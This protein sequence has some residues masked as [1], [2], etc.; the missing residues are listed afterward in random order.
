MKRDIQA[1]KQNGFFR[2][3]LLLLLVMLPLCPFAQQQEIKYSLHNGSMQISL[4]KKAD[5][6]ALNEFIKQYD[7]GDLA[8]KRLISQ[9]FTDS[10]ISLGWKMEVN[11]NEVIVISKPLFSAD[12]IN[13]PAAR[14]KLTGTVNASGERVPGALNNQPLGYNVFRKNPFIVNDRVV[15]FLLRNNKNAKRV[16]LAGDFTDW[17]TGALPMTRT[18]SAWLLP[19]KM[20]PGKYLYKFIADGNWITDPDNKLVENDGEGNTNSVYFFTNTTFKLDGFINA[21]KVVVSGSFNH[22]NENK[23]RMNKTN[24]GWEL[25][26]F[27]DTGTYTYRFIVDGR[28]MTDPAN[29]NRYPNEFNEFNSVLQVGNPVLFTLNSHQTAQQVFLAGSFNDWREFELKLTRTDS[30]WQIPYV[31]GAGNYEYK[32]YVDGQWVDAAGKKIKASTPGSILVAGTNHVFRLKGYAGAK[33]IFLAGDFNGW[34]PN[35][36]A[37]K[38]E[39]DEWVLPI[40]LSPGKHLYKFVV[41]GSWIKDPG[42]NLWEK[43]EFDGENSIIWMK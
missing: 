16:L 13:D 36:F 25:P 29:T 7:L 37:M 43:N 42:N 12:N 4:G 8:L 3:I 39:G 15:S 19:V 35:A 40:H 22:W 26:V 17:E 23:L 5:T 14:I 34:S 18:D 10:V 28:W 41:D 24:T 27:L 9:D 38:K 31:L 32:F 6:T 30:G 1:T 21:K 33:S 11:S 2:S 20:M